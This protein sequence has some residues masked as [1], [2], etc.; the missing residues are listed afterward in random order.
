MNHGEL[1]LR[2]AIEAGQPVPTNAAQAAELVAHENKAAAAFA[3]SRRKPRNV[4]TNGVVVEDCDAE[5]MMFRFALI[6]LR[7]NTDSGEETEFYCRCLLQWMRDAGPF[8]TAAIEEARAA[9][10]H[11]ADMEE[12][13]V[14]VRLNDNASNYALRYAKA[15]ESV[16][17]DIAA[18]PVLANG[19]WEAQ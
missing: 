5:D 18:L 19:E 7:A 14:Q 17:R 10:Q 2:E 11:C 4:C 1:A 12:D 8:T 16:A 15:M 6:Q 3:R 13:A 9:V